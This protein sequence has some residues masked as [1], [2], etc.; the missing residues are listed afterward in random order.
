V[1]RRGPAFPA[2]RRHG[3]HLSRVPC[4]EAEAIQGG[5]LGAGSAGVDSTL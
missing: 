2:V 1:P 3:A 4:K 5:M